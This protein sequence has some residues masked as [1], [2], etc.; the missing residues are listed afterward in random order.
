MKERVD[1]ER[2]WERAQI[3]AQPTHAG[4]HNP[5]KGMDEVSRHSEVNI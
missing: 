2:E 4:S 3:S 1:K 5:Y